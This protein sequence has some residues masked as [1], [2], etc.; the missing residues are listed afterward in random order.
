[1]VG[2]MESPERAAWKVRW[3]N[4]DTAELLEGR[5]CDQHAE[6]KAIEEAE[7]LRA[8]RASL[9]AAWEDGDDSPLA[10]AAKR[11]H[12]TLLAEIERLKAKLCPHD[13][14]KAWADGAP[15]FDEGSET[16]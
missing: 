2:D 14:A 1:M 16:K 8:E 5:G 4:K 10:A 9:L 11:D 7:R 13:L 15:P 3:Q 12:D 6:W